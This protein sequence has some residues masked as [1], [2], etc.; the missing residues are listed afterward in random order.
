MKHLVKTSGKRR[1]DYADPSLAF[2]H[3]DTNM[4]HPTVILSHTYRWA[5]LLF[6]RKEFDQRTKNTQ[7]R[8]RIVDKECLNLFRKIIDRKTRGMLDHNKIKQQMEE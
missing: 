4:A 2:T 3:L 1:D 5:C 7:R 8:Y 6:V